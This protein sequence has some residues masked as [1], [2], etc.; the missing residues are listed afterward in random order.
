MARIVITS[1][2][3]FGDVNPY[4]ALGLGLRARGHDVVLCMPPYYE[5]VVRS[6]GLGF[7]PGAPDADPALDRSLVRK[8]MHPRRGAEAIFREVLIPALGEA[9]AQLTAA[10]QGADLVVTHPA[11][12][13]APIVVEQQRLRWVSTILSPL[14]FMSAYD[15]ILPPMAPW[16]RHLPWSVH[17]RFADWLAGGGRQVAA[18]WMAPVQTFRRSLGLPPSAHPLFEGQHSPYA[19]LALYSQ[20]FGGPHADYPPHVTITGQLRYDHSHGAALSPSLQAFLDAGEAPV[21]FTLGT[22][23]VEVA[24][25]FWEESIAAVTQLGL[26]GVLL[27]GREAAPRVAAQAPASVMVVEGAPHSQLFPRAAAVVHQCGMGTLGTAFAAGV[28]QLAVPYA[29]DQPDNA[30]RLERLAV[31]R[32]VYPARYRA[33]RVAAELRTLLGDPRYRRRAQEVAAVVNAEPG[34]TAACEVIERVLG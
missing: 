31:A 24:G 20:V 28:P 2:G 3:S 7:A 5:P 11:A 10:V 22:S 30:W 4:L 15:P 17:L 13:A 32:T 33:A 34:V 26:R 14:N 21:V 19:V 29:N 6:A 12:L 9:H 18:R 1:W 16:L 27:A 8:V 25:R 23:A